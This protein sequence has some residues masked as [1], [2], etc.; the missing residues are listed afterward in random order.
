M[1]ARPSLK[2]HWPFKDDA[3]LTDRIAGLTWSILSGPPTVFSD[4]GIE[5][6]GTDSMYNITAGVDDTLIGTTGL[7]YAECAW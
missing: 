3:S 6:G 7:L 2:L 1:A 5:L 4:D